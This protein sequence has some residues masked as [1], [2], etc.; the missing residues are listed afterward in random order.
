MLT[1]RINHNRCIGL[2]RCGRGGVGGKGGLNGFDA[3]AS[4][5]MFL[6]TAYLKQRPRGQA[7]EQKIITNII[8]NVHFDFR[9]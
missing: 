1:I 2:E 7:L 5:E 3:R 8:N 4:V 9:K 6:I